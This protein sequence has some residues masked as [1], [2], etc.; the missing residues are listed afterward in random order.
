MALNLN[1]EDEDV[2]EYRRRCSMILNWAQCN[3]AFENFDTSF[4]EELL[5]Q[6]DEQ[7]RITENQKA[8]VDRII[9]AF[10]I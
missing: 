10:K 3:I 7:D 1:L 8:A 6:L 4:V 2:A 9:E 5:I